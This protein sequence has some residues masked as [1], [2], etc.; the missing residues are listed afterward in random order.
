[1]DLVVPVIPGVFLRTACVT[2]FT[3][4]ARYVRSMYQLHRQNDGS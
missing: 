2:D 1:V 3:I 4:L